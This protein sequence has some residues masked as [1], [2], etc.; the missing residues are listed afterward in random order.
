MPKRA[1]IFDFGGVIFKTRD[2]TPRQQWD[3]RLNLP[4]GTVEQVVHGGAVWQQ[5]QRGEIS[6][7]VYW[8]AVAAEL[9]I[10]PETARVELARDF[11]AGDEL[12][13]SVVSTIHTLR[14]EGYTVALLS[15]DCAPMLRPR[16]EALGIA[17]LFEPIVISSEIGVM[18]PYRGAYRAVLDALDRPAGETIF[19]DD[20]PANIEGA[21]AL[22]IHGVYYT[23]GMD[24]MEVLRPLL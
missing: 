10:P 23:D 12:T 22:G 11:Y 8:G 3:E 16:L 17:H 4:P 2:Y 5:A 7:D 18:K 24:L 6:V 19:I 1:V 14:D 15:N 13:E 21:N 9:G 20:M